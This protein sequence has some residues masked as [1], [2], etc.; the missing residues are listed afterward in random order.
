MPL[1]IPFTH[2]RFGTQAFD[3]VA[4]VRRH[5]ASASHEA[6]AGALAYPLLRWRGVVYVHMERDP[7]A[8]L[9]RFQPDTVPPVESIAAIAPGT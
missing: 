1:F 5:L 3:S 9:F 2:F 6:K 4:R 8:F 7:A